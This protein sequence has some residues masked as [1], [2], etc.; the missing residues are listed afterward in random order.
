MNA[1]I[2]TIGDE[3]LIGQILDTN[4]Q[5]IAKKLNLIGIKVNLFL[6]CGDSEND[7]K[8]SLNFA[9]E[10]SEMVF[11]TGGLGPTN[12]D[13]TKKV[14]CDY[15]D[16]E[17]VFDEDLAKK[18]FDR[19]KKMGRTLP[20]NNKS[21]ALI[22][23]NAK[24]FSNEIGTAQAMLFEKN[25]KFVF[26]TPGVPAE[27]IHIFD[28][29][30]FKYLENNFV[31]A[32]IIHKTFIL[33][34]ISES[35]LAEIIKEWEDALPDYFKLAYLPSY[36]FLKIRLSCYDFD[37]SKEKEFED[38]I[39][40]FKKLASKNI[41]AEEDISLESLLGQIL[42]SKKAT[43]ST[44]ESCT[45]GAIA[46][47]I[48]SVAGSSDYYKGSIIAYANE[49]KKRFLCVTDN[50]IETQ[51]VVSQD[52]V[53]EMAMCCSDIM[54]SDYAIAVSG[55]AGPEGGTYE[56]P[57]GTVWICVCTPK[58]FISKKI[59]FPTSRENFIIRT[60]NTAIAML[61]QDLMKL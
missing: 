48:V 40:K 45:G 29:E 9:L 19:Y 3:I 8:N 39:N 51:G 20:E 46:A 23:K 31:S 7:I 25:N 30:L 12:D 5:F 15:F 43:I 32:N 33:I 26:S 58:K 44:A 14:L 11:I 28:N 53:E 47:K 61:L 10:N 50:M 16:T 49:I 38:T 59:I 54:N 55:I 4:S 35:V 60:T 57:V 2:I 37:N 6:S 52:V 21:Q 27:T 24:I 22:P 41:V 17:L 42:R 56:K 18:I 34:D 36:G 13:I 1:S